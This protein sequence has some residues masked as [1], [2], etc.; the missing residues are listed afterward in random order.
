MKVC[1]PGTS[2]SV[3]FKVCDRHI[4]M[5]HGKKILEVNR[6]DTSVEELTA[7]VVEGAE[8][9]KRF[10]EG[11][12]LAESGSAWDD[13]RPGYTSAAG[14]HIA[15]CAA[16]NTFCTGE[17]SNLSPTGAVRWRRCHRLPRNQREHQGEVSP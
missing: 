10:R 4:M 13:A 11:K 14:S 3:P 7:A 12:P 1:R 8:G 15:E 5:N 6:E 9:V 2:S 16:V 17:G